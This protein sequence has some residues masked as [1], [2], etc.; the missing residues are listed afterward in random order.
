M[1][2]ETAV[3][4]LREVNIALGLVAFFWLLLKANKHWPEYSTPIRAYTM[5]LLF[6]AFTTAYSSGESIAQDAP[7]GLRSLFLLVANGSLLWALWMMR[8]RHT[9]GQSERHRHRGL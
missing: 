6:F 1:N 7:A 3:L 2:M 9:Y 4:V 5:A 8:G